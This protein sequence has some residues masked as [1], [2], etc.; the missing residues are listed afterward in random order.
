MK[1]K[2]GL[3]LREL[4]DKKTPGCY[5]DATF[6]KKTRLVCP[7]VPPCAVKRAVCLRDGSKTTKQEEIPWL[8]SQ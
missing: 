4:L 1:A 6:T 2:T 8:M 3:P 5:K 7:V